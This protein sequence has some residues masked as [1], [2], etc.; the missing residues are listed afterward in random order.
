MPSG[1]FRPLVALAGVGDAVIHRQAA[2]DWR[3]IAS[4]VLGTMLVGIGEEAAFR[5]LAFNGLAEQFS[6]PIAVVLSSVLF[7]FLHS[8]N[9]LA[10][11]KPAAAAV[12]VAYTAIL[13][14][15]I[16][17]LYVLSGRNLVLVMVWH[18]VWDFAQMSTPVIS[19][20]PNRFALIGALAAVVALVVLSV[21]GFTTY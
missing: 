1:W 18:F 5:G 8:V 6:V 2:V 10:G 9:V 13:G 15:L 4:L 19:G 12:Q 14:M 11:V 16:A 20:K 3:L 21:V 17:W 7:G